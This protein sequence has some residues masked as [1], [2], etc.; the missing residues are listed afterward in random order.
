MY[1]FQL[2][3]KKTRKPTHNQRFS[4]YNSKTN[5]YSYQKYEKQQQFL[6]HQFNSKLFIYV[7]MTGF[8]NINFLGA[9]FF[10]GGLPLF[11]ITFCTNLLRH[12]LLINIP[13]EK[14]TWDYQH[15]QDQIHFLFL[16]QLL[17]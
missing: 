1:F 7:L 3:N 9:G 16:L 14:V 2:K 4:F 17:I 10:F 11:L 13:F 6:I 5:Q 15:L 12:I 8:F